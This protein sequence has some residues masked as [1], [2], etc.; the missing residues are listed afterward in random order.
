MYGLPVQEIEKEV[1]SKEK[2][3]VIIG[4]QKV[5]TEVYEKAD[6]NVSVT[7]QP[8]SEIAALAVFLDRIFEGKELTKEFKKAKIKVKPRS[9]GKEVLRQKRN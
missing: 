2:V 4:S 5:E 8:H 7:L 9:T 6:Y 1:R 3:L